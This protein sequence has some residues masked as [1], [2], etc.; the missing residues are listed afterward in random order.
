[1]F[2]RFATG[3]ELCKQSFRVLQLDKELLL[4][5]AIGGLACGSQPN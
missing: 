5:P 1:M 4:F 2:Q 3:W